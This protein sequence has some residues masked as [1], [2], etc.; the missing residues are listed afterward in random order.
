VW[1]DESLQEKPMS[2]L[3]FFMQPLKV[4]MPIVESLKQYSKETSFIT[5]D[6]IVMEKIICGDA[7]DNIKPVVRVMGGTRSYK[8]STNMWNKIKSE[9]S[10]ENIKEFFTNKDNIIN[11]ILQIKKF[12]QCNY[13][14]IAEMF[15]YNIKLVWLNEE[16][17]PETI[18]MYMNQLEYNLVDVNYIKSNFKVMCSQENEIEE[19]FDSIENLPF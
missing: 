2:D 19:I 1:F 13:N 11:K 16:V 7:G 9:L 18:I 17:I 4:K 14:D 15:D 10:I 5:P 8:I 3:D 6:S 12:S